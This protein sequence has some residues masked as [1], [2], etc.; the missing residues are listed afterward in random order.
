MMMLQRCFFILS[1]ILTAPVAFA[2]DE[3][4]ADHQ[5]H[6]HDEQ[7][8][9]RTQLSNEAVKTA[10]IEIETAVSR[11]IGTTFGVYGRLFANEDKVAHIIPRFPG[12]VKKV[13]KKLGDQVE[14]G[15][16]LAVVESNQGLQLYEIRSQLSGI[17]IKRHGTLGEFV[18]NERELFVVADL[19]EIWADFQ[20]YRDDFGPVAKGQDITVD[21][22]DGKKFKTQISYIAPII[23]E[24]TQ[25]RLI[26]AIL[27]N[28]EGAL[29][30]GLFVTG[31]LTSLEE[32]VP[33]AVKR[34]AIQIYDGQKVVFLTDGRNFRAAPVRI[35][36]QDEEY[37][38]IL[39]GVVAGDRYV[40]KNSFIIKADIE[41]AGAAHHH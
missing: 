22:G 5:H 33:V 19:S 38:Q 23:D 2:G 41:K 37:A 29:R 16:L 7:A 6:K 31:T 9:G 39:S 34:S 10:E 20:I 25:S 32:E 17:V 8:S 1:I 28:S 27:P 14:K 21:L 24:Q 36:R 15:E 3:H 13:T 12:V 4:G 35:G 40:S 30:P 26:R 18:S 11:L